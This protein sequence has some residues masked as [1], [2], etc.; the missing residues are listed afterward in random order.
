MKWTNEG[1][2]KIQV[3]R[4]NSAWGKLSAEHN[5]FVELRGVIGGEEYRSSLWSPFGHAHRDDVEAV[6]QAIGFKWKWTLTAMNA[7]VLTK[8]INDALEVL[9]AS[10]PVDDKR[11][12]PEQV[13][14]EAKERQELEAQ[15][16][17]RAEAKAKAVR[18]VYCDAGAVPVPVGVGQM[19]VAAV[20]TYDNSDLQSDYHDSHATLAGPFL[21]ALLPEGSETQPK[22]RAAVARYPE[23]ASV[24]FE[25]K[26]E[27][28]SMGHGNYLEQKGG[29]EVS[30]EITQSI[31]RYGGGRV[32]N[33]AWEI[34]FLGHSRF[35][36]E[37]L[38][39]KGYPGSGPVYSEPESEGAQNGITVTLNDVHQ[40]VEIRFPGKPSE[41]VR[42]SLKAHGFRWSRF[43]KLW[44]AK[45]TEQHIAFARSL[46]DPTVT[47]EPPQSDSDIRFDEYNA[48]VEA[49]RTGAGM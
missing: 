9:E 44:Y 8:E 1:A 3:S 21:L 35:T 27:K 42:E 18:E 43:Q 47:V 39:F 37:M 32:T 4:F 10:R 12:T 38:P 13:A 41:A 48:Q 6:Q 17:A 45:Q 34:Q 24:E 40:G 23:L 22:A 33:G 14:K 2:G 31:E 28:Y 5:H 7:G 46:T 30:P 36:S 16:K 11:Q 25:W 26:T 29:F 20:L 49:E 19:A 15:F